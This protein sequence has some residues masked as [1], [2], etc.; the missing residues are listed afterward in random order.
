MSFLLDGGGYHPVTPQASHGG[1]MAGHLGGFL[2]PK[3]QQKAL[4]KAVKV[5]HTIP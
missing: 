3:G 4:R 1:T 2:E 5:G